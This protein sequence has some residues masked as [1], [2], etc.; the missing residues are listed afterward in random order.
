MRAP[1]ASPRCRITAASPVVAAHNGG[2][3]ELTDALIPRPRRELAP[4]AVHVPGWL[5]L[6]HQQELVNLCRGWASGPVPMRAV[7]MPNGGVMSV[8]SVSLG[9][10]WLPYRYSRTA[11]DAG[12]GAVA[13]FP[14]MLR[15]LGRDAAAT[16]YGAE[17][18][19]SYEPDAALVNYYDDAAKM[20]MHQDREERINAPVVS[21]SLGSACIFRFGNTESRNRPW[22]DVELASGDLFVFG[23][24]SRFAYHGVLRTLPGTAPEGI[25]FDGRLNITLRQT[26][27]A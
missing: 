11:D 15:L 12:G 14:A 13:P 4:G 2:V 17:A 20:G 8:R 5:G 26:G 1:Q 21:L 22:Q 24:P 3:S 7:T 25:G 19:S 10:H 16:A 9:W 6:E 23:G 27:L 18:G